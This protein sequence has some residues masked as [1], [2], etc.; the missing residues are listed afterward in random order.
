LSRMARLFALPCLLSDSRSIR[1]SCI[2]RRHLQRKPFPPRPLPRRPLPPRPLPPRPLPPRPLPP[3]PLPPRP[4]PPRPLPPRPPPQ[5]QLPP[6]QLPPTQLPPRQLPPRQ[7]PPKHLLQLRRAVLLV[8][9][10]QIADLLYGHEVT[11]LL[12]LSGADTGAGLEVEDP[13]IPDTHACRQGRV[14][15][16]GLCSKN[17]LTSRIVGF[18]RRTARS[19]SSSGGN[20]RIACP[21]LSEQTEGVCYVVKDSSQ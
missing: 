2:S 19:R 14:K 10:L 15:Y 17:S 11:G 7:L 18:A 4:L 21:V 20:V 3:R 12:L 6:T 16:R 8:A 9:K 5:I 13:C 1:W